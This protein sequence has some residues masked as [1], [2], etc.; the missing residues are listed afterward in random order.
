MP[1]GPE[2][3]ILVDNLNK[4]I[5]NKSI[6]KILFT[7]GRYKKHSPPKSYKE[8][9]K[10]FPSKIKQIKSKG[11]FIYI[12]LE[13]GYSIWITLGMTG[14]FTYDN[15]KHSDVTFIINNKKLYFNDYRHFGTITFCLSTDC[16]EKKLSK[17]GPDVYSAEF[18]LDS[19]KKIIQ[20]TKKTMVI[21][22]FLMNQ[23]KISGV[24]NY[25]RS[26]IFYDSYLNPFLQL[27]ELSNLYIKKLYNSILKIAKSS[28]KSQ[29]KELS[30]ERNYTDEFD[31][32]VYQQEVTPKNEEVFRKVIN[33]RSIFYVKKQIK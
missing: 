27:K 13:G 5:K 30:D 24:G 9:S 33:G 23:K 7:G 4:T 17:L 6:S 29:K 20:K 19:L 2:V 11:K 1:E 8:F 25:M 16:L 10:I 21:A 31:F 3:K 22:A 28:Y 15:I 32:K 18:T 14:F 12:I 26:E